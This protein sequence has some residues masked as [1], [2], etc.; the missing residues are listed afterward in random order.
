MLNYTPWSIRL[1][2]VLVSL[3]VCPAILAFA[4]SYRKL[5]VAEEN[6]IPWPIK[7][8]EK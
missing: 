2:P 4:A 1:T 8:R 7:I 3:T 6:S 5:R